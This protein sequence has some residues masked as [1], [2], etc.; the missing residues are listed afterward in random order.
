VGIVRRQKKKRATPQKSRS[1]PVVLVVDDDPDVRAICTWFLQARGW[2]VFTADD[3]A[4]ALDQTRLRSPDVIVMD[5]AMPR[6]DGWTAVA[7]LKA[8]PDTRSIPIVALTA[9]EA[10]RERARAIGCSAF[11]AKPCLPELLLWQIRAVLPSSTRTRARRRVTARK[12]DGI[13]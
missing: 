10:A 11:L 12:R 5:L 4:R 7:R 3:G 2:A 1:R 6:V 9:V 13:D 8:S